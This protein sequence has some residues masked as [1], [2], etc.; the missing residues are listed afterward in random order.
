MLISIWR[1]LSAGL[2]LLMVLPGI[3]VGDWEQDKPTGQVFLQSFAS[4]GAAFCQRG[5]VFPRANLYIR[6][7]EIQA[8]ATGVD[9]CSIGLQEFAATF[10]GG[11]C[12]AEKAGLPIACRRGDREIFCPSR[13]GAC[14]DPWAD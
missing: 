9:P 2:S 10:S 6:E 12:C 3:V 4:A 1:R 11:L 14:T 13:G 8:T 7:H 5:A